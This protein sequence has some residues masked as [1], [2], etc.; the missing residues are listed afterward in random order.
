M[1]KIEAAS[2]TFWIA[3]IICLLGSIMTGWNEKAFLP[4]ALTFIQ[5]RSQEYSHPL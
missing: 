4:L 2:I 3:G 5:R 1:K